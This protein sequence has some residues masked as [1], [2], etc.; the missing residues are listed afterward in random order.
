M[1]VPR[2]RAFTTRIPTP[3]HVYKQEKMRLLGT[4]SEQ[5]TEVGF[6]SWTGNNFSN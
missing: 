5:F 1:I 2:R 3:V 4:Y 6:Y